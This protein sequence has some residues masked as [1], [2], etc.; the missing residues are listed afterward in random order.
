MINNEM[1][2]VIGPKVYYED[3]LVKREDQNK[4]NQEFYKIVSEEQMLK[5]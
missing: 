1:P 2:V 3:M 4:D 5:K